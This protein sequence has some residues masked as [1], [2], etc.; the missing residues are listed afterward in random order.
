MLT[1]LFSSFYARHRQILKK[2][3]LHS[4]QRLNPEKGCMF[5][6]TVLSNFFVRI[7][8]LTQTFLTPSYQYI[9]SIPSFRYRLQLLL[10]CLHSL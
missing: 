4:I 9:S 3:E 1:L 10:K 2:V 7:K 6:F 5:S 8:K